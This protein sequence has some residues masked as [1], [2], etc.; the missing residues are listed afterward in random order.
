MA[1]VPPPIVPDMT[2]FVTSPTMTT[3]SG[4]PVPSAGWVSYIMMLHNSICLGCSSNA[5]C[6]ADRPVCGAGA[7]MGSGESHTCGC[8]VDSDCSGGKICEDAV[9]IEGCRSQTYYFLIK[10]YNYG[11]RTDS[12]CTGWDSLCTP[13]DS[14]NSPYVCNYCKGIL[15]EPGD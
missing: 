6:P 3:A 5:N 12:A 7:G 11:L 8:N 10:S 9:C 2:P 14:P 1:A 13:V 4:V 15:C